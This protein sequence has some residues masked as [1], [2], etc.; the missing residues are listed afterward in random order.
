MID[1]LFYKN[2]IW[3]IHYFL[4]AC[5]MNKNYTDGFIPIFG[6]KPTLDFF[7]PFFWWGNYLFSRSTGKVPTTQFF[8]PPLSSFLI[9]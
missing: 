5:I 6:Q 1:F 2:D 7:L 8:C 4:V 9:K 3:V